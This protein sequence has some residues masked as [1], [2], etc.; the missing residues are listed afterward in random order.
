[1]VEIFSVFVYSPPKSVILGDE[2]EILRQTDVANKMNDNLLEAT[3]EFENHRNLLRAQK[4]QV[5]RYSQSFRY[6]SKIVKK[7]IEIM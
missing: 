2:T 7:A 6:Y 4:E 1:L 3:L 5:E